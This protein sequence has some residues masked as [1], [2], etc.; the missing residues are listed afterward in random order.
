MTIQAAIHQLAAGAIVELYE[1]DSTA[2]GGGVTRLHAGTNAL[3]Q[4]VV[5]QGNTYTPFPIE[6]KGFEFSSKGQIPRPTVRVANVN[7]LMGALVRDFDDLIGA[8]FTRKRTL[9][10]FLDAVN[11]PGG[12]NPTA[13][14]TAA[15]PDDVFFVDRKS[16]EN[17]VA[18]E[19]ELAASFDVAGIA[20]PRRY[21]VQNVCPWAYRGG[22]CGYTGTSYFD[23]NDAPVGS[24]GL[25]VCGKRLASC[26]ARFGS[27]QPL[28]YGGF[29]AAGLT[30]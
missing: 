6:V 7:G 13:D 11:F 29:P 15:L 17:K 20:L 16:G 22:E 5:W 14:P 21:I 9:V 27:S 3:Q 8:K 30:R 1:I 2:L 28:P 18:I 23:A 19:W 26:K 4:P 25:D 10:K 24:A 12:V